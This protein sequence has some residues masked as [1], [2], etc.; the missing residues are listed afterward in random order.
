M[1]QNPLHQRPPNRIEEDGVGSNEKPWIAV[2][3]TRD[4]A[5][6]TAESVGQ[7][8]AAHVLAERFREKA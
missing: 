2:D 5:M 6:Q 3:C 1:L 8:V 4:V 7:S